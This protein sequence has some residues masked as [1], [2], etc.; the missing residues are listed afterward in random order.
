MTIYHLECIKCEKIS[1]VGSNSFYLP[2]K[3]K[4]PIKKYPYI[5]RECAQK[6]D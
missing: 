3:G 4:E 1:F 2:E 5:C 6:G